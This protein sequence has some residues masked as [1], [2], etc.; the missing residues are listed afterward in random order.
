[1]DVLTFTGGADLLVDIAGA[2]F[3][4][5]SPFVIYCQIKVEIKFEWRI[6][7]KVKS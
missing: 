5:L 4:Y 1:M 3:Q 6:I 7:L 2:L